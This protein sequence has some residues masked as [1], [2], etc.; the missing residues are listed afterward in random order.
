MVEQM[1]GYMTT[2]LIFLVIGLLIDISGTILT[3]VGLKGEDREKNIT[4]NKIAIV[5]FAIACEYYEL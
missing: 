4:Y 1:P 2:T 5:V 3:A